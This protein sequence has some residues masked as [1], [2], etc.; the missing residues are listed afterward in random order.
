M[1]AQILPFQPRTRTAPRAA[2]HAA[3]PAIIIF[4]GVRYERWTDEEVEARGQ[5]AQPRH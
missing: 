1:S 4:P 5:S 2:D 3:A